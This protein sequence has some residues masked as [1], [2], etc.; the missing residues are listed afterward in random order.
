MTLNTSELFGDIEDGKPASGLH[1]QDSPFYQQ[2]VDCAA[3][4]I[5]GEATKVVPGVGPKSSL[6]MFLGRN[7]GRNEDKMGI[8]FIGRG[9]DELDRMLQALD[10]DRRKILI[11]NVNKC[12]TMGDRPPR[13]AEITT[14][15]SLWL[16]KELEFFDKI[17]IVF[18]LG[19]E[20]IMVMLGP[21]AA[22]PARREGYW[23]RVEFGRRVLNVCPLNHPGYIIRTPSMQMR[24]YQS[25][26]PAVKNH[27]M[28]NLKDVYERSRQA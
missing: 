6:I 21:K 1:Y 28:A 16:N 13:P 4:P 18:A 2:L 7:P 11:T 9:G 26:L 8:P 10:I 22:S 23:M 27:L 17:E 19:R 24:M 14:C 25:T 5:R 3:C 20:A 12:H 15:T